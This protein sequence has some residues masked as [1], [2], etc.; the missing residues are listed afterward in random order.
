MSLT[1]TRELLAAARAGGY[2]LPAFNVLNLE[3]TQ[4][5][6]AAAE[7]E[8][9][10]IFVAVTEGALA[11]GG[12]ALAGL[13]LEI[14]GA[15]RTPAA[16][17]LDHGKS[18]ETARRAVALGFNS[19]MLDGSTLPYEENVALVA[20]ARQ[21]DSVMNEPAAFIF[22]ARAAAMTTPAASARWSGV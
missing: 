8:R 19:I 10:P 12:D 21:E 20:A 4:A 16:L 14:I 22:A 6:V 18:M 13:A 3:F 15:A 11:H 17:H 5:V 2:A 1:D 9:A 7:D